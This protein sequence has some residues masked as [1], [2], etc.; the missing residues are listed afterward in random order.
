MPVHADALL[1]FVYALSLY[2][3][4]REGRSAEGKRKDAADAVASPF[5]QSPWRPSSAEPRRRRL[6]DRGRLWTPSTPLKR[7]AAT[8]PTTENVAASG[9]ISEGRE[10]GKTYF[11]SCSFDVL[12]PLFFPVSRF[13]I[14]QLTFLHIFPPGEKCLTFLIFRSN[15]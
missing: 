13:Y 4:E 10:K 3:R 9:G 1:P 14:D 5:L 7:R 15:N 8:T 2:A 12:L 6:S 11:S